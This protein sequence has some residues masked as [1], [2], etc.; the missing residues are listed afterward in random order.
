ML[1]KFFSPGT[2]RGNRAPWVAV[3]F[4]LAGCLLPAVAEAQSERMVGPFAGLFG[5]GRPAVNSQSLGLR[6]S[7]FGVQQDV[8]LP[9]NFDTT[10]LDPRFQASSKFAGAS[11]SLGYLFNR[12]MG[13]SNLAIGATGFVAD[14]SIAPEEPQYGFSTNTAIGFSTRLTRRIALASSGQAAYQSLY[15]FAP[16]GTGGG[17]L[18]GPDAFSTSNLDSGTLTP[19]FGLAPL[20]FDS[21]DGSGNVALSAAL[22]RRSTLSVD[23]GVRRTFFLGDSANDSATLT[24]GVNFSQQLVRRLRF[25][26]GYRREEQLLTPSD[27]DVAPTQSIDFGLDYGDVLT[28]RLSRRTTL[29]MAVS[30]G[31]ARSLKGTTQYNVLGNANLTHMM[32]R[33]WSTGA[34]YARTLGFVSAFR[35]PVLQDTATASL[36]GQLRPRVSLTSSANYTRG[37]IGLDMSNSFDAYNTTSALSVALHRRI[38]AFAQYS[39]YGTRLPEGAS[40]LPLLSNFKRSAAVV[41]V[42]FWTPLYNSS[43][44]RR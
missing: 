2:A 31:S 37:Y 21:I 23:L 10:L 36:G 11:S 13:A 9:N 44:A 19:G 18:F 32:G 27:A 42:S 14:Y 33:T 6:A 39:Y 3:W 16:F 43:R 4:L 29:S 41:G 34:S 26:V 30:A 15:S 7:L 25:R 24:S 8:K 20:K 40:T 12:Q 17:G 5:G 38:S 1:T 22:T 28:L 35:Q